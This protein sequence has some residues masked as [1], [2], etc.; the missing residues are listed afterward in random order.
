MS[1][2]KLRPHHLLCLRFFEGKGYSDGFTENMSRIYGISKT[3]PLTE[4]VFCADLICKHCPECRDG[5]CSAY[6]KTSEYDRK[7]AEICGI[8]CGHVL[9]FDNLSD[10]IKTKIIAK[11]RLFEICKDCSW[12]DICLNK[13]EIE[14]NAIRRQNS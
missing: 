2:F 10:I 6:E 11:G 7:V 9:P 8:H 1:S 3:N 13:G 14:E 4:I 12:A 5:I